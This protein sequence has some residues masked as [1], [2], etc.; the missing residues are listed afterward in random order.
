MP[1]TE[2]RLKSALAGLEPPVRLVDHIGAAAAADDPVV[3][4]TRLERLER[5]ANLHGRVSLM[6]NLVVIEGAAL[7]SGGALSPAAR[8][9]TV[10][11]QPENHPH[12]PKTTGKGQGLCVRPSQWWG[13]PA[14][15]AATHNPRRTYR[16]E[17]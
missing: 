16:I 9:V 4:V 3:A 2:P 8:T 15:P 6:Q 14:L 13:G 17:E 5:V 7:M 12:T 10:R 1:D 11:K